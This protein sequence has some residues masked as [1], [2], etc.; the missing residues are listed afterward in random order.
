MKTGH[1]VPGIPLQRVRE[2][3]SQ[4]KGSV[5]ECPLVSGLVLGHLISTEVCIQDFLMDEDS[6]AGGIDWIGLNPT[7]PVY[8]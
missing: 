4:V 1:V 3:L 6:F 5:V 8:I 2:R 7:L